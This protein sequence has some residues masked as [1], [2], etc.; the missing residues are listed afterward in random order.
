MAFHGHP[1]GAF[2]SPDATVVRRAPTRGR[3]ALLGLIGLLAVALM[4]GGRELLGI[5]Q[6]WRLVEWEYLLRQPLDQQISGFAV[7]ALVAI[8]LILPLVRWLGARRR[9]LWL[10]RTVHASVGALAVAGMAVHTGLRLGSNLNLWLSGAFLMLCGLGG[11]TGVGMG[12]ARAS[13]LWLR[14]VRL[15]HII[16]VWPALALLGLHVLA[17]Y[18]Y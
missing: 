4:M 16:L 7:V 17:S 15:L 8:G 1:P 9:A 13:R 10:W 5:S 2:T 14:P 6:P 11:L 18:Y 12:R 3:M